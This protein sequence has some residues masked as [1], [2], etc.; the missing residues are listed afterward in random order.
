MDFFKGMRRLCKR[1]KQITL[2]HLF[3]CDIHNCI[4]YSGEL[5]RHKLECNKKTNFFKK[6]FQHLEKHENIC[7]YK[8]HDISAQTQKAQQRWGGGGQ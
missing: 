5:L 7:K 1:H 6:I 4:Q 8:V 3:A 2:N